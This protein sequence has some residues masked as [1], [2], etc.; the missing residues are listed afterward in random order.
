M[1]SSMVGLLRQSRLSI[2]MTLLKLF[3]LM[4][5]LYTLTAVND[6]IIEMSSFSFVKNYF[7]FLYFV[8][9]ALEKVKSISIDIINLDVS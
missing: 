8:A 9:T 5:E 7:F 4:F 2:K 1:V 3:P 6:L